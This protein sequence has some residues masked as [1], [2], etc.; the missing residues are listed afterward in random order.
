MLLFKKM[1]TEFYRKHDHPSTYSIDGK[2]LH[3][4]HNA[5]L[6]SCCSLRLFHIIC[7]YYIH[8]YE[9][10]E[11]VDSSRQFAWYKDGYE[12]DITFEYF[13]HYNDIMDIEFPRYFIKHTWGDQFTPYRDID[14][15]LINPFLSKY[16]SPSLEIKNLIKQIEEEYTID[17]NK[18]CVLYY[19]GNDKNKETHICSHEELI[20]IAKQMPSDTI[21]LI[22]SDETGFIN[23]V[24]STFP[25]RSFYLEKYIRHIDH[26][27][28]ISV[29]M[30]NT[31]QNLMYSKYYLA[32]TI[33]MARC[34][35]IICTSGNCSIWII[36][37]RGH[38]N[39][40]IQYL[41]HRWFNTIESF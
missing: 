36:F 2:T 26:N 14:F 8:D 9:L 12:H 21:F 15:D 6:F 10:P 39:N 37:Y 35:Y 5:G 4:F 13:Q 28:G 34:K 23:K 41:N 38:A 29:D 31:T 1:A 7:Y 30:I 17:Y 27:Y 24:S 25:S 20:D 22:Q 18:I 33:I 3:S 16:F 40:I 19:R 32:I 11:I